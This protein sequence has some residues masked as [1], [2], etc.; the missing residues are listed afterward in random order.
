MR[1]FHGASGDAI[2]GILEH[3]GFKPKTGKVFLSE[4]VSDTFQHGVDRGRQAALSIEVDVVVGGA[5][6]SKSAIAN[7]KHP[8]AACL[9]REL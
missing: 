5:T 6:V 4:V 9:L 1:A 3:G 2:L 8:Q 7:V